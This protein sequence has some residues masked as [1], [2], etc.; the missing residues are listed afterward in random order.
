[1][2][3]AQDHPATASL[4]ELEASFNNTVKHV[5]TCTVVEEKTAHY[6]IEMVKVIA[7][8][9]AAMCDRP[10]LSFLICTIAPLAMDLEA[11]DASLVFAEV[12]LPVGFMSMA[13]GGLT[14]PATVAGTIAVADAE[15]VAAMVLIQLAFPGAP[16]YYSLMPSLMDRMTGDFDGG[17]WN[18]DLFSPIGVELAHKWGVPTLAPVGTSADVSGWTSAAGIKANMLKVAL[19]GADIASG[20]GLRETCTLL[21]QEALVLDAEFYNMARVD[22][23]GLDT[24]Q[25]AFSLDMI[26]AV[27][28]RGNFLK[29]KKTRQQVRELEYS[30]LTKQLSPDG[31]YRDPIEMALEKT[32]WI[33]KNHQPEPLDDSQKEAL[34]QI[35]AAADHEFS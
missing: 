17:S 8:D 22:A 10:P 29:E 9:E 4:H 26:K 15:I 32:D 14:S 35:L 27:G 5:Q 28:P 24:S 34:T 21:T 20:I 11:M 19:C 30:E 23:S 2:V 25:E 16:V 18:S 12:G 6:A 33:L 13:C 1:M 3:S 7:R 31:G